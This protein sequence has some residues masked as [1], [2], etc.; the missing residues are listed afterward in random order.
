MTAVRTPA[1]MVCDRIS[2]VTRM[3][4]WSAENQGCEWLDW[5]TGAAV[6]ARF[7]SSNKRKAS[8]TTTAV[9]TQ[10]EGDRVLGC[11]S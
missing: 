2:D 5:A 4:Q 9:V 3:G 1:E 10:A 6:G 7:G 8:W 11:V